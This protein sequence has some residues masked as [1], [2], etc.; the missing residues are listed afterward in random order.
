MTK[1]IFRS[2]CIVAIVVFLA[3]LVLIMEVLYSYFS[4]RQMKSLKTETALCASAVEK[5]GLDYLNTVPAGDYRITWIS[6]DGTVLFDNKAKTEKME[7]HLERKEIREALADGVG[8]SVR[9]SDTLMEKQLYFAQTLPDGTVLRLSESYL[10][11][12]SL[13]LSML[14]P[15]IVVILIAVGLSLFLAYRLSRNIVKPL[16]DLDL[17]NPSPENVYEEIT[18]FVN[19]IASQQQQ[20]KMQKAELNQKQEE[21]D[22]ATGYMNEGIIL[23]SK[24]GAVLSINKAATKLLGISQYCVGKDLL[25]FNNSFEIQELLRIAGAGKRAEKIIP[26]EE[27]DYQFNASPIINEDTVSGIALIIFDITD[28]E[29]AE[30]ARREFTANV[31]HELKTPLQN[32]S[33]SA[34]LLAGGLVKA[35]DVPR[36]AEQ[37]FGES[38]RMITLVEDIIKLSHLDEGA[39]DMQRQSVDL[40]ELADLT[41]RNLTPVAEAAGVTLS[42][43]GE[44]AIMEGI[45]QLLSGIMYNLCDNAVKY[46]RVGGSVNVDVKSTDEDVILTIKDTGIGIPP[47]AQDRI[48]ERF[49]RVD[50][51]RSKSV[52]GTGLGLS[53]VKHSVKLH[54]GEIELRSVMDKGTTMIITLPKEEKVASEI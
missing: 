10:A 34:E 38:K 43:S 18:P 23:L 24:N 50:K 21:F 37:I 30:E 40:Y 13:I 46:N 22:T 9:H 33:G 7:N 41:V 20:L 17:D 1:R 47:E 42:L 5:N 54:K 2:I 25:L 36:F 51:S 12:W 3:S 53:I 52:G 28:K 44:K 29:K 15:I 39:E 48:F 4:D 6:S 19:R 49:Y 31:S 26:I 45:P 8:E 32:I 14:Q 35:E 27:R 16:N 11:L